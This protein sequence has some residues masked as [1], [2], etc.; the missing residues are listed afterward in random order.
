MLLCIVHPQVCRQFV[1]LILLYWIE[2]Q[3]QGALY[4]PPSK[5]TIIRPGGMG[6]FYPVSSLPFLGKMIDQVG[7]MQL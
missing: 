5:E 1:A 2:H 3:C 6:N 7:A 4:L